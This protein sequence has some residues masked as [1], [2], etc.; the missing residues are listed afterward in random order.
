MIHI[1]DLNGCAPMPL[2]HYLKA[3]GIL[4]LVSEQADQAARGWWEG[5]KF[6]LATTLDRAVIEKFFLESYKPT[7]MVAPW[8][9]G[10]G[11]FYADDPGLSPIVISTAE[12]WSDFRSAIADAQ[13][14]VEKMCGADRTIRI[15]KEETKVSP[16]ERESLKRE[17]NFP[18][19]N[20]IKPTN[21][22]KGELKRKIDALKNRKKALANS[23]EY[24]KRLSVA[25]KEF[26]KLK[27]GM[28]PNCRMKWRGPHR[29]WL[30]AAMV[31]DDNN[32]PKFPALLGT[33]G[34]DGR[35]DF[36]NNFMQRLNEI[37]NLGHQEGVAREHA[38]KWFT[39]ALWG[40]IINDCQN[41]SAVGQYMP[42]MAGGANNTTGSSGDSILNPADF[43]LMLEGAILF[44]AHA[45]RKLANAK[46][47]RASAPFVVNAHG[48]GYLSASD[49][50]ES[51]RGEQWMPLWGQ[52][53][54]LNELRHLLSEGR[55][56]LGYHTVANEPLDFARAVAQL[57][58]T[59]GINEFQRFGYIE[60][61]GQA[62]LAVPLGR[63]LVPDK[64][65]PALA[66]LDDLDRFRWLTQLRREARDKKS[67]ARL[68]AA[69]RNLTDALFTVTQHPESRSEWQAV[70]IALT[71][72]E[73]VM[74][75]GSGF[76]AGPVPPLRPEWVTAADDGSPEFRLAVAFALQAA[77]FGRNEMKRWP[78]DPVRRHW[79]PLDEKKPWRFATSGTGSQ[80]RL[81]SRSDVVIFGRSGIDDAI[82]LVKR[83]LIEASQNGRRRLPLTSA[84]KAFSSSADLANLLSGNVDIDRTIILARA[85]MALDGE[86]WASNPLPPK[87]NLEETY[88][89]D[90]WIAIR[91][92]MLPWPLPDRRNIGIDPAIIRRLES[93][94]A[95]TAIELAR[96]RLMAAGI[97][98]TFHCGIVTA[99][100]ARRWAAAL[101][102]PI[103]QAAAADSIRRLDP[104]A[105]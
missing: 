51:A 83:R 23:E 6:R 10:S 8:N 87:S 65:S 72:V 16:E 30:D 59:R 49:A 47:S 69:E 12:R 57:G 42:G 85:L 27:S 52:P 36:T 32:D 77:A 103:S 28:F 1:H 7:P 58:T 38:S 46:S 93:G 13:I 37:Y 66:C 86:K 89:D 4:R 44:I 33:G 95:A 17:L 29:E 80:A 25:N 70:L 97:I 9:K 55:S 43:I 73:E 67:P 3:L 94:D 54:T 14:M 15:I 19:D 96:R 74:A 100:V 105:Q 101:A 5:E 62:N 84:F 92:A 76:R 22:Q 99:Q 26:E 102:F 18:T 20:K 56:Q 79:L 31:L 61:N 64:V 35:L 50:D 24:K 11:F 90:A 68:A 82:A 41:G 60:R 91:L 53:L 78:I 40:E 39:G 21:V 2:A 88:P 104:N 75:T 71:Q 81:E 34:N 98:T 45:T 48:S 63:F